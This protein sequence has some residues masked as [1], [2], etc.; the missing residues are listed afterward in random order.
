MLYI[1]DGLESKIPLKAINNFFSF[2]FR[3][4][5]KKKYIIIFLILIILII[6]S[7]YNPYIDSLDKLIKKL[8]RKLN[9]RKPKY[10]IFLD[11][12]DSNVC[13]DK[14]AYLVFQYLQQKNIK[15]IYYLINNETELYKNL[16]NKRE[17]K[18]I[19]P[20]NDKDPKF[21]E[22]LYKYLVNS[23]L[24][25]SSYITVIHRIVDRVPY[26]KLLYLTHAINYFK[27]RSIILEG[28]YH[29]NDKRKNV[30]LSS[31]FEYF[32]YQ[33]LNIYRNKSLYIAGLPRY[34]RFQYTKKNDSEKDCILISFTYR[35]YKDSIYKKSLFKQNIEKLITDESL[36]SFLKAKNTDLVISQHHHDVIRNRILNKNKLTYAKYCEQKNLAHYI[37]QCSLYITDFSTIS[38][39]FMFQNKP[40][41]FYY[42]DA[43]DTINFDDKKYMKVEDGYNI[44]FENVFS[45]QEQLVQNIKY[46]VNNNYKL[47]QGL[48][49]KYNQIFYTKKNI[50]S[51]IVDII[52]K[53]ID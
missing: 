9:H 5:K 3:K 42:L 48:A 15:N 37:E 24:I 4:Q 46:Y 20:M 16:L 41:L 12:I 6:S 39:D 23:K 18:N 36:I 14:N 26:L 47:K 7:K 29:D 31:P 49:N 19:I 32:V 28:K 27:Y 11:Y 13:S 52:Y 8:K 1:D 50:T 44:F 10:I 30:I 21:F 43:N 17:T 40:V 22:N 38:F 53:I 34:D 25:V 45:E 35:E 2:S 33:K 51:K